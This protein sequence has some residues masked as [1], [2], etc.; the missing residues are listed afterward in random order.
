[1]CVTTI[2]VQ[3]LPTRFSE[4]LS[5]AAAGSEVIVTANQVP[6]A[7]LVPLTSGQARIPGL[8][9]GAMSTSDDFDA[10]LAEDFWTGTP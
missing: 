3:E 1:M 5:L 10:P 2:D 4:V 9:A 6:V 7:R 8:H